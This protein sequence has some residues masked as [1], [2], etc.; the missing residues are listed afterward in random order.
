VP[1]A[2]Y[3]VPDTRQIPLYEQI[4]ESLERSPHGLPIYARLPAFA[5]RR[6]SSGA[7]AQ[8]VRGISMSP[9]APCF[10]SHS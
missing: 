4:G 7:A 5:L 6:A 8:F 1:D 10:H 9:P 3:C 2:A